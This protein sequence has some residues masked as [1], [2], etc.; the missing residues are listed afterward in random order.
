MM[1]WKQHGE[2]REA[3]SGAEYV[4]ILEPQENTI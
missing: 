1:L 2:T 3:Y 4:N